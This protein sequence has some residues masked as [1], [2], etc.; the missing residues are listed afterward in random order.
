M[1]NLMF[2]FT[3]IKISL[4]K[5]HDKLLKIVKKNLSVFCCVENLPLVHRYSVFLISVK[6]VE[7]HQ[8]SVH[9]HSMSCR[10][11]PKLF[12]VCCLT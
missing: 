5:L 7:L 12:I 2:Y 4:S 3:C 6:L 8:H 9:S 1:E 11:K 10:R